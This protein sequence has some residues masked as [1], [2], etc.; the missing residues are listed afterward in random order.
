MSCS[1]R[2][3]IPKSYVRK[4]DNSKDEVL[5]KAKA[6]FNNIYKDRKDSFLQGKEN[7]KEAITE[8]FDNSFDKL[9]T[10]ASIRS[11]VGGKLC[12]S[13]LV[14][15]QKSIVQEINRMSQV[16][17]QNFM[18]D[19]NL[20]K[21][22]SI[23]ESLNQKEIDL[24]Q[25]KKINVSN[26][27]PVVVSMAGTA[28]HGQTKI[29]K[30]I[31]SFIFGIYNH[32]VKAFVTDFF[33]YEKKEKKEEQQQLNRT[34]AIPHDFKSDKNHY[35]VAMV[36]LYDQTETN[37][38]QG[39]GVVTL[40]ELFLK[41]D[42]LQQEGS[43]NSEIP[44]QSSRRNDFSLSEIISKAIANLSRDENKLM[45]IKLKI[46]KPKSV[47]LDPE[48]FVFEKVSDP[49]LHD[50]GINKMILTIDH[51]KF[52]GGAG[53]FNDTFEISLD[54]EAKDSSG[55]PVDCFKT[56][57]NRVKTSQYKTIICPNNSD[58]NW[59]EMVYIQLDKNWKDIH[60][61][62]NYYKHSDRFSRRDYGFSFLK[63]STDREVFV[64]DRSHELNVFYIQNQ[65]HPN[66]DV[67]DYLQF[68]HL[69][70]KNKKDTKSLSCKK[71]HFLPSD[72]MTVKTRLLSTEITNE[73]TIQN[74]LNLD[75]SMENLEFKLMDYILHN[76]RNQS[77]RILFM[78]DILNVLWKILK[79]SEDQEALVFSAFVQT[80]HP[81]ET[82]TTEFNYAREFFY[83]YING[84][85][86]TNELVFDA[87]V[88]SFSDVLNTS[89]DDDNLQKKDM[90][91]FTLMS[92]KLIIKI[93]VVAY[94]KTTNND[95]KQ[96]QK[97]K[98]DSLGKFSNELF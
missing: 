95:A 7:A 27:Y 74:I 32:T 59:K 47:F 28:N 9:C 79:N 63:L 30:G 93:I 36:N 14:E 57:K 22:D 44:I 56:S 43:K 52:K 31:L 42:N 11:K 65:R 2:G 20:N 1:K 10:L 34:F 87:L 61:K 16:A 81:I 18:V 71:F 45:D 39:V 17:H 86:F 64:A 94:Q 88:D 38:C 54:V 77:K 29:D 12:N 55:K 96:K 73:T 41:I 76:E 83:Q 80:I 5:F 8:E 3:L 90:L 33:T 4:F 67:A 66:I 53:F 25:Q 48:Y 23:L 24:V 58:C 46:R 98:F 13:E 82:I 60:L 15:N 19:N 91:K 51:G 84:E 26:D 92:M 69:Y 89:C 40:E 35:L 85:K 37:R 97:E 72:G 62:F 21:I 75:K 68:D 6:I 49:T 78:T 50:R 70:D